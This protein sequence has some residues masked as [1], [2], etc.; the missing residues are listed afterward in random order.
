MR[1]ARLEEIKKSMYERKVKKFEKVLSQKVIEL[2]QLRALSWNG[3]PVHSGEYRCITWK[4]L[5]DYIPNDQE[6]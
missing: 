1:D 2:D 3:C 5:L 4:L 6:I